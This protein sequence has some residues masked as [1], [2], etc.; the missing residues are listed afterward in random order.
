MMV[1]LLLLGTAASAGTVPAASEPRPEP[2]PEQRTLLDGERE[3]GGYGGPSAT[4]SRML[5]KNVLLVGGRGAWLIDRRFAV[6]AAV[7]GLI[8]TRAAFPVGTN[9]RY[10]LRLGYGGLWL[11]YVFTPHRVLHSTVGVLL[12]GGWLNRR[13]GRFAGE[14]TLG[15]DALFVTEP[16]VMTEVNV[17]GFFRI[18]AGVSY[19]YMGG[20]DLEGLESS[21]L[22]AFAGTLYLKF[23]SF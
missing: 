9:E 2:R 23:G 14:E 7:N 4:Y 18:G 8:P 22:S 3:Y 6:G 13:S 19:R 12:G 17:T 16:S 5:G 20:V 1:A 21:D 15:V 11:E 10:D